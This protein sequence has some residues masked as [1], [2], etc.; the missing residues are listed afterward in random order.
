MCKFGKFISYEVQLV[1]RYRKTH[2]YFEP[3]Y[4]VPPTPDVV[5]FT[6]SFGV[7][8]GVLICFDMLFQQPSESLIAEGITDLLFS[9]WW[10]NFPPTLMAIEAQQAWSRAYGLNL[11]ASNNGIQG[12]I[13]SG[14][15]LYTAGNVIKTYYNMHDHS[16]NRMLLGKIPTIQSANPNKSSG[17]QTSQGVKPPLQLLEITLERAEP[18]TNATYFYGNRSRNCTITWDISLESPIKGLTYSVY[19]L[20]TEGIPG[21][22][23]SPFLSCGFFVCDQNSTL[24]SIESSDSFSVD[25]VSKVYSELYGFQN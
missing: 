4:D 9:S 16:D 18:G 2:L 1:A 11:L 23:P 3:W 19:A 7:K 25:L 10:R 14:T 21:I 15:G 6:S 22:M 24:C 13:S 12:F 20:T 17:H 8:F 5:S